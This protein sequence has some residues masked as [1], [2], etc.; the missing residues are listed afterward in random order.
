LAQYPGAVKTFTTKNAGDTIQP[1]HLNDLQDEVNAI[2]DG[3][4]NGTAPIASSRITAPASQITNST[5]TTLTATNLASAGGRY[6]LPSSGG[7]TGDV[8]TCVSTSGSTMTLEWRAPATSSSPTVKAMAR[9]SAAMA[10]ISGY[11]VSGTSTL[12]TGQVMVRFA[13]ALAS[14][15]YYVAVTTGDAAQRA[16]PAAYNLA[17]TGFQVT[18]VD[19]ATP[20]YVDGAF[21][22]IV[23]ST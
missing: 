10:L 19:D 6:V 13:S 11:N 20:T 7:S 18:I 3:L 16:R 4:L 14:S 17:S 8:L 21:H 1:S 15:V 9:V 22:A 23:M 2:E 12:G 5:V